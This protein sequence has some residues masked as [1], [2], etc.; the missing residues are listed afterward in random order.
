M[1][2]LN[3][4][5]SVDRI[6]PQVF[7]QENCMANEAMNINYHHFFWPNWGIHGASHS[8]HHR[9]HHH[10]MDPRTQSGKMSPASP[11]RTSELWNFGSRR[12]S[13]WLALFI[14]LIRFY[15]HKCS[16]YNMIMIQYDIYYILYTWY[17][18]YIYSYIHNNMLILHCTVLIICSCPPAA[19]PA[20]ASS[21]P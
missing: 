11:R 2:Y 13:A 5:G 9:C 20:T 6:I 1:Y 19:I 10:A 21:G 7:M 8:S 15:N 14:V 16:W 18:W 4:R 17:I 12:S 3:T